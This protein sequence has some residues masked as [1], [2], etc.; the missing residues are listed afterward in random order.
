M[1]FFRVLSRKKL[2]LLGILA[3]FIIFMGYIIYKDTYN[4]ASNSA[5]SP[6]PEPNNIRLPPASPNNPTHFP[7]VTNYSITIPEI[8]K[9]GIGYSIVNMKFLAPSQNLQTEE[10]WTINYTA[11]TLPFIFTTWANNISTSS[12]AYYAQILPAVFNG[13]TIDVKVYVYQ[14]NGEG[15]PNPIQFMGSKEWAIT[16]YTYT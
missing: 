13:T 10:D 16:E 14:Y 7:L 3:I 6:S 1:L 4:S 5:L 8:Y 15:I 12:N 9:I 11:K 2:V